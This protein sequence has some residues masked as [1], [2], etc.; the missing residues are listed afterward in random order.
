MTDVKPK[1]HEDKKSA[2]EALSSLMN[3]E[4]RTLGEGSQ[5]KKIRVKPVLRYFLNRE[6]VAQFYFDTRN[7]KYKGRKKER[8]NIEEMFIAAAKA[9]VIK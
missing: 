7:G 8:D 6:Q 3:G 5:M 2:P 4:D 1:I 9:G